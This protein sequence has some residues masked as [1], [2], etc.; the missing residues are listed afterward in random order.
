M[1]SDLRWCTTCERMIDASGMTLFGKGGGKGRKTTAI[2]PVT[3]MA[4]ILLNKMDS[5]RKAKEQ[6]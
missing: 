5:A 4:H 6:K 3:K 2:D 1:P